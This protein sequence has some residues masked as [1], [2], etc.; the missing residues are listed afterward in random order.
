MP[1]DDNKGLIGA[2]ALPLE[3]R[4]I[5]RKRTPSGTARRT[6]T[7][8]AEVLYRAQ[9]LS[10]SRPAGV[11]SQCP[12][13]EP[14]AHRTSLPPTMPP[15]ATQAHDEA[16]AP[17]PHALPDGDLRGAGIC[18]TPPEF[19]TSRHGQFFIVCAKRLDLF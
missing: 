1:C 19:F 13:I 2:S 17:R 18:L 11:Q 16:L 8:I 15:L 3:L 5:W 12:Y 10:G 14:R 6:I 4:N 7:S 9:S